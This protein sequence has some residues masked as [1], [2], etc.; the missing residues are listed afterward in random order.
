[1]MRRHTRRRI[2]LSAAHSSFASCSSHINGNALS[3][4]DK[5]DLGKFFSNRVANNRIPT[6]EVYE[7]LRGKPNRYVRV[8]VER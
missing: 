3:N 1:M 4:G 2:T 8:E 5:R 7:K 6:I